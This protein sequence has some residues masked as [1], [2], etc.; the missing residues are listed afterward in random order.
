MYSQGR[1]PILPQIRKTR[2]RQFWVGISIFAKFSL[3]SGV[4]SL[5]DQCKI[6]NNDSQ[7]GQQ[8]IP[9]TMFTIS[10]IEF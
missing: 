4:I 5:K 2:P 9:I 10:I 1:I 6:L 7:L 3:S 8:V